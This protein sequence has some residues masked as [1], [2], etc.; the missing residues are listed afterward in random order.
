VV[1]LPGESTLV[2]FNEGKQHVVVAQERVVPP[3]KI[4]V[5][6]W[7]MGRPI[8]GFLSISQVKGLIT[9]SFPSEIRPSSVTI[10]PSLTWLP[11]QRSL[12]MVEGCELSTLTNVKSNLQQLSNSTDALLKARKYPEILVSLNSA[13]ET[14][15]KEAKSC[16]GIVS[17]L[18]TGLQ[19]EEKFK[20][21]PDQAW[22]ILSVMN[23]IEMAI[24]LKLKATDPVFEHTKTMLSALMPQSP[25]DRAIA[26]S[27]T[28]ASTP[29]QISGS[30]NQ[31][32]SSMSAQGNC[33]GYPSND[34]KIRLFSQTE[35][36]NIL[37]GKWNPNGECLKK[38][39]GS[40]SFDLRN[41]NSVCP[42]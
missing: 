33:F 14:I 13:A 20:N 17:A 29:A 23:E 19:A 1:A 32:S 9:H 42:K 12:T 7:E 27:N 28:L 8:T 30:L 16:P 2:N 10:G 39:G 18:S 15:L 26:S 25:S 40:Y 36:T 34:G 38:E 37:G 22:I 31:T 24:D 35:C 6:I 21:K 5:Q 3:S 11:P 41:R 4:A